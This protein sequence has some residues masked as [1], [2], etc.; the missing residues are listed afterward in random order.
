MSSSKFL[1]YEVTL[2]LAK[3]GK[4]A[5]LDTLARKLQFTPEQLEGL[6]QASLNGDSVACPKKRQSTVDL[7][8]ELAQEYPK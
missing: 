2:L 1:D 6:L 8:E 4:K 5:L 7:V 3:Y